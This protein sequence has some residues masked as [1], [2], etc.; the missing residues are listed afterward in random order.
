MMVR[1]GMQAEQ[2]MSQPKEDSQQEPAQVFPF[3][4]SSG[5]NESLEGMPRNA[6]TPWWVATSLLLIMAV[7]FVAACI[8]HWE[9]GWQGGVR[10]FAEA[11]MVGALADW[12]AVTALFRRPLGLP[13]PH[14]AI[15]PA[16]KGR[17]GRSLGLFVQ[18]NFLSEQILG[19]EMVNI[20]AV[21]ARWLGIVENR[22]RIVRRVRELIPQVLQTLNEDEIRHFVDRQAEDFISRIDFAKATGRIL[23]LLTTN[24]MHEV[25]LDEI[26]QESHV[27]FRTNKEWL[28]NQLREASPWFIPE[29]V[30]RRIFD[31]IV[32]RTEDTFGKAISDRK[33]ELR[34]R[35]HSALIVF[36]EKLEHSEDLQTKAAAFRETLLASD[37]FRVY[38]RSVRDAVVQEIQGDIKRGD[39]TLVAAMERALAHMVI[40]MSSSPQLQHKLN[41]LIRGV[42]RAVL[43]NQSTH[44][45]DLISRTIDAWDTNTL[46]SKLEEQVGYDLQYIRINGTLVGGLVGLMLYALGRAL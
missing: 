2:Y 39:S 16:N 10:A 42:L 32:A 9:S 11:A 1:I 26:V 25:L 13:I 21:L 31:S 35:L 37:V 45:A 46:V 33:H 28:R 24:G 14:T 36:I 22:A 3:P 7:V 8:L 30:D 27:F 41:Q 44:V 12:F 38:I 40:S 43:G 5:S 34:L 29:F 15:I 17:I 23:R 19:G 4:S 6:S 18:K 20:S